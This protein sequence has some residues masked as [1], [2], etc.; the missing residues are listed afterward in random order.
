MMAKRRANGE[1]C[2]YRRSDGRWVGQYYVSPG[3]KK[4]VSGKT[5]RE[6]VIKLRNA[7][8]ELEF[9]KMNLWS[10]KIMK[11]DIVFYVTG[12]T[13]AELIEKILSEMNGG[14]YE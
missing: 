12:Q 6:V 9:E 8:R 14:D 7:L 4:A 5:Q 13:K 11:G 10:A 1:G 2:I 3:K